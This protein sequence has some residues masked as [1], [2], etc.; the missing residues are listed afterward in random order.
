MAEIFKLTRTPPGYQ[1]RA[2]AGTGTIHLYGLIGGDFFSEG[3]TAAQFAKDLKAMGGVSTINLRI[4]SEG[5][6]VFQAKAMHA[7][8]A[9]HPARI[10]VHVDGLAGSAASFLAM[11]GDEIRIAEG[12]FFMVHNALTGTVGNAAEHRTK[13]DLL[14]AVDETI[15]STYAAR[16]KLHPTVV[17]S[18][19]A[20]E[21]WLNA[22]SSIKHG[23][24]DL[25]VQS[26]KVAAC[27]RHPEL[28]RNTP[29]ELMP[30]RAAVREF[31]ANRKG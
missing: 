23:F 9:A 11:V 31:L 21:T 22:A 27:V 10:V 16:T 7:L 19:M 18:L 28:Y 6:D 26:A 12:G 24:A 17:R 3:I 20:E 5:G 14:D 13:A 25:I 15:V 2:A 1:M 30:R 8:L 4:N 29:R